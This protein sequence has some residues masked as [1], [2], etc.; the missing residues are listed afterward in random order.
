MPSFPK[1]V[2]MAARSPVAAVAAAAALAAVSLA[3]STLGPCSPS[4]ATPGSLS[5][6]VARIGSR[7]REGRLRTSRALAG[8]PAIPG[9]PATVSDCG[10]TDTHASCRVGA[11]RNCATVERTASNSSRDECPC[12][13]KCLTLFTA[14][15]ASL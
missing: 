13:I 3:V 4:A 14:A 10:E 6:I 11:V 1:D 2:S 5:L 12:A 8:N 9:T 7:A 15:A